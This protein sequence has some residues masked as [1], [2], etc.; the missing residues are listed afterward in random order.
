[1]HYK[2]KEG[3]REREIERKTLCAPFP[4]ARAC[5]LKV[6]ERGVSVHHAAEHRGAERDRF[7]WV[8]RAPRLDAKRAPQQAPHLE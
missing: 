8:H 7:V 5:Y 4:R 3:E 6:F 1:M 2:P